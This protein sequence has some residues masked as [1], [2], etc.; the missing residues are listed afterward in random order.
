MSCLKSLI[1]PLFRAFFM[2][3]ALNFGKFRFLNTEIRT[4]SHPYFSSLSHVYCI[5][6]VKLYSAFQKQKLALRQLESSIF[7]CTRLSRS[8]TEIPNHV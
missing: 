5:L 7:K 8:S 4:C 2:E 3:N 1:F 6:F